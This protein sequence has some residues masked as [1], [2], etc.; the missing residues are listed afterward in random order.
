MD[1][2]ML[3]TAFGGGLF[4]AAVGG[5]GSFI[6]MGVLAIGCAIAAVYTGVDYSGIIAWGPWLGPQVAFAGGCAAAAYAEHWKKYG[7]AAKDIAAPLMGLDKPD[8]LLVGGIF[9]MLGYLIQYLF[10]ITGIA[11]WTNPIA[12]SIV[13]N[14]LIVR[15]VFGK[16]GMLGKIYGGG[17]RWLPSD[18]AGWLPWQEKPLQVIMIGF[19]ALPAAYITF[20][21]AGRSAAMVFGCAALYLVFLWAGKPVPVIHHIVLAAEQMVAA[22]GNVGWGI[23][24]GFLGAALG[25]IW[26][27]LLVAH[28]DTFIDPPSAALFT[29]L[30][31]QIVLMKTGVVA[32][33]WDVS[34]PA[35]MKDKVLTGDVVGGTALAMPGWTVGFVAAIVVAVA[36][37]ALLAALKSGR[38]AA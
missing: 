35:L 3:I 22:T 19:V 28:G 5:L 8:V 38:K 31:I 1:I 11:A 15:V 23:A 37:Y 4:G 32:S 14:L 24:M 29:T 12:L 25:E 21:T 34:M 18:V 36:C 27:C 13:V 33:M 20:A 6:L 10:V 17:S 9:G 16:T 7:N 26:A 30:T 2:L